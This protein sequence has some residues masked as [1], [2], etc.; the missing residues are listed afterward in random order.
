MA[1]AVYNLSRSCQ[2]DSITLTL[3]RAVNVTMDEI[4]GGM[5]AEKQVK[6]LKSPMAPVLCVIDVSWW[7]VSNDNIKTLEEKKGAPRAFLSDCASGALYIDS[8]CR[9]TSEI[10]KNQ[11]N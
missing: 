10:P 11:E 9:C 8:G 3:E 7:C 4:G 6:G 2:G 5:P 1:I